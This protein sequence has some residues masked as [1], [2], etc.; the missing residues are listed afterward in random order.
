MNASWN[1]RSAAPVKRGKKEK[2]M[3][4]RETFTA[5]GRELE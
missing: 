1:S 4:K 2:K 3:V 5:D